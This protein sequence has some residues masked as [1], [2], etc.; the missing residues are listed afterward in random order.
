[1]TEHCEIYI[2]HRYSASP[3][4]KPRRNFANMFSAGK[5]ITTRYSRFDIIPERD[6]QTDRR[7]DGRM[8][9]IATGISISRVSIAVLTRDKNCSIYTLLI[10][11]ISTDIN[12]CH[13]SLTCLSVQGHLRSFKVNRENE[14][15][16]MRVVT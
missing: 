5:S 16:N 2:P 6:R 14:Q 11:K 12:S 1:L 9:R 7:T 10:Q 3:S 8:D 13:V 15:L 4:G